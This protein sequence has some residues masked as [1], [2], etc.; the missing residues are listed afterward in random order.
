MSTS[1]I[2]YPE[3]K[4]AAMYAKM[5]IWQ[6]R[7]ARLLVILLICVHPLYMNMLP[8]EKYVR[9]TGHK[10]VFFCV[11]MS[12]VLLSVLIIWAMRMASNPRLLPQDKL[13]IPDWAVLGFAAVTIISAIFSPYRDVVNV[14]IGIPEPMGRYDGAITQLLYV[15]VFFIVSRWYRPRTND[16]IVFGISASLV[17]I[18]G[19]FQFYGMDFLTLWPQHLPDFRVADADKFYYIFFRTTLGNTNIV[20]T[21]ACAAILLCGFL[22]VRY[23]P[24]PGK[25]AGGKPSLVWWQPLWLVASALNFWLMDFGGADSGRIGMLVAILFAVPFVVETIMALGRFLI[26]ASSWAAV[27]TL[28]RLFFEVNVLETRTTDSLLP[29]AAVVVLLLAAGLVLVKLGMERDEDAPAKWKV[30]VIMVVAII[31]TGIVG[32]EML[33]RQD[34]E[35]GSVG[36]MMYEAREILHGNIQDEFGTNRVY[37]WRNA[38][39]EFPKNPIIGSGPDTF[40]AVFPEEAQ[41]FYGQNYDTAHNEYLQILICQGIL[42]LL[43]YLVFLAGVLVRPIPMAFKNPIVMAVLVA[44]VGYCAQAFFNISLPIASQLLWVFAGM[45]RGQGIGYRV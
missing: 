22:F 40:N 19:I 35:E 2:T 37:I 34:S 12:V 26:L 39:G 14:W 36:N 9:L 27:Y 33:G 16:F 38:I 43:F 6:S 8:L 20:S 7:A 5:D 23:T 45:L 1:A 30:G 4:K 31:A 29:Y 41:L 21:Y 18:I 15:A 28:Q 44:F 10:Y 42:G 13:T 32:V 3:R 24:P 11:C 25:K 17:A